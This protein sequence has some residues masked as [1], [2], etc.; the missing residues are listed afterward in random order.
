MQNQLIKT[1]QYLNQND[2]NRVKNII[3]QATA[4]NT[5]RAY[6]SDLSYFWAWAKIATGAAEF[7]PLPVDLLIRFISDHLN[8]PD[9]AV[10]QVLIDAGFKGKPGPHSISTIRRR[11]SSLSVAHQL[12]G[13]IDGENPCL[14][15]PVRLLLS[16]AR[17]AAVKSGWRP[18][19]KKAA[20]L[21]LLY[22]ML[23][24]CNG[25]R[26]IDIR[27]RALLF[28][29][30]SS[31]GRRR[32]E[33]A[34]ARVENL[35]RV[36]GGYVY[37][38]E[39]SKTDQAGHGLEVPLLGKAAEALDCWLSA[40]RIEK[41]AIFRPITKGGKI[42]AAAIRP[43]TV[44]RIVQGRAAAAGLDPVLFGGHSLRSGF[45]TEAGLQGKPLGDVMAMSG[46]KTAAVAMGY[47]QA[48]AAVHNSA[49]KLAG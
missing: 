9:P 37:R 23:S 13:F 15:E 48:G 38:L 1:G 29:A 33:V 22:P 24:T 36:T 3:E 4:D 34:D 26:L 28:F 43:K 39:T 44:A 47:Y 11:V 35:S 46:H 2:L 42:L 6:S 8:G 45:I 18:A 30:F 16:K 32:S 20:T 14:S 27:D 40:A 21:D 10:D 25:D 5:R 17:S 12:Q 31:G 41:G 7:Y 19:K 49:A